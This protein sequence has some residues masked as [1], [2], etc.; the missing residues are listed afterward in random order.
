MAN[1]ISL[2]GTLTISPSGKRSRSITL[3]TLVTMSGANYIERSQSIGTS[4]E[5]LDLGEIGTPGM[6]YMKNLDATNYVTIQDGANGTAV[7]KILPGDEA[8]FMLGTTAPYAK[9]NSAACI[10]EYT[11]AEA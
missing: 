3:S 5:A 7:A 8:V 1:E 10:V 4:A 9:A 6:L 2:T 11:I